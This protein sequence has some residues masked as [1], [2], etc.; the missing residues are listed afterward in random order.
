MGKPLEWEGQ[1]RGRI[2]EYGLQKADSGAIAISVVV[3]LSDFWDADKQDWANLDDG[4]ENRG[5]FWIV[6]K[7][8][9]L[10]QSAVDSLMR[11]CGWDGVLPSVTDGTWE[12]TP[13]RFTLATDKFKDQVRYKISWA[14]DYNTKPGVGNVSAEEARQLQN[15]Y[16]SQFR[17]LS[18]NVARN[19]AAPAGKPKMPVKP[20]ADTMAGVSDAQRSAAQK[21]EDKEAIPF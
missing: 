11:Y 12:P 10:N 3:A 5:D 16:G 14:A 15:Q 17:A 20:P 19:A 21:S 2:V 1:V 4:Y 7:N 8:G 18:G 13:A 6:K 9:T